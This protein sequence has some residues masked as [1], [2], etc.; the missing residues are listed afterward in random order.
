MTNMKNVF[1]YDALM[2]RFFRKVE[3]V[4]WDMMSGKIGVI[5]TEGITTIE[6]EGDDAQVVT[7]IID[8][9]G[10]PL[11]AFAQNTPVDQVA[12]GDII[13]TNGGA[14]GWV[15]KINDKSFELLKS[16]GTRT[17]WSPPKVQMLGFESGVMVLRSLMN[18]LPGGKTGLEAMQGQMLPMLAMMGQ[19]GDGDGDDMLS[20]MLPMMLMG[21]M[22]GGT[23]GGMG[24]MNPMMLMMMSKMMGSK[25]NG[26]MGKNFF[27]RS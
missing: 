5:T 18:M 15:V 4:V 24:G 21:Q 3:G 8:Q 27:D 17:R 7:N 14:L 9:F 26:S 11:P 6:G 19:F 2:N 25:G 16:D 23:A 12:L 10:V 22:S 13:Y 1:N 20:N